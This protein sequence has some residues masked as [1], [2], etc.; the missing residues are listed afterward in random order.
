MAL[1]GV[2]SILA[3]L[4]LIIGANWQVIPFIFKM[5]GGLALLAGSLFGV[6]QTQTKGHP[7]LKEL[8]LTAAFFLVAANIGLLQQHLQLDFPL[9]TWS[10]IWWGLSLPLVFLSRRKWLPFCSAGL[11][12]FGLCD[13]IEMVFESVHYMMLCG[14]LSILIF[15]S[16]L[17]GHKM[18]WVRYL[19]FWTAI[20]LLL[21]GD[22]N[23][24]SAVGFWSTNV[25][26]ISLL[27]IYNKPNWSI[28]FCNFL[29]IFIVWRIFL[30]FCSAYHNLMSMGLQL[31]IFGTIVLLICGGYYYY[32]NKLQTVFKRLVNHE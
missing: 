9:N 31:V 6:Y 5:M 1:L 7:L 27:C 22:L 25:F 4:G 26:L 12:I 23:S 17:G 30:L 18:R 14:I 8:F 11:L 16:F 21:F 10:L 20:G 28:R 13:V 24:D 15:V 2:L 19:S 3:G 29:T 32:F